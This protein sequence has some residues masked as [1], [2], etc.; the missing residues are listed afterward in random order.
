[1]SADETGL[2]GQIMIQSWLSPCLPTKAKR[3]WSLPDQ[4]PPVLYRLLDG[5]RKTI[6]GVRRCWDYLHEPP[7][8][9]SSRLFPCTS[10]GDITPAK[11]YIL[12]TTACK[13]I[14]NWPHGF[15]DFLDAYKL[16]DERTEEGHVYN[17]LG[18]LYISWLEK[19]WRHSAFQFVQDA[20]DR[21]LLA[22]YPVVSSR[23]RRAQ[24]SPILG[25]GSSP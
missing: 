7:G 9:V 23:L 3:D 2:L 10:K 13:G 18:Y 16:R 14:A 4:P 20:F 11:S 6:M 24:A 21:Y 17:D 15:H 19:A 12:Y 1:V 25:S 5:L 8:C 22:H